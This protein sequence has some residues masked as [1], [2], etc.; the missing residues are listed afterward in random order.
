MG[1]VGLF[2]MSDSKSKRNGK[3]IKTPGQNNQN[4]GGNMSD[5][6]INTLPNEALFTGKTITAADI[7]PWIVP[8]SFEIKPYKIIKKGDPE[9]N[10]QDITLNGA[11]IKFLIAIYL[12]ETALGLNI[13][14]FEI[15][16]FALIRYKTDLEQEFIRPYADVNS[17]NY[18]H[19]IKPIEQQFTGKHIHNGFNLFEIVMY[20]L[21]WSSNYYLSQNNYPYANYEGLSIGLN[22]KYQETRLQHWRMLSAWNIKEDRL[23]IT[24]EGIYG[25]DTRFGVIRNYESKPRADRGLFS[26]WWAEY[27]AKGYNTDITTISGGTLGLKDGETVE[28]YAAII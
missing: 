9:Y 21:P 4:G 6:F 22:I 5:D 17:S 15:E 27:V 25:T 7:V 8:S 2:A 14:T 24:Q 18:V 20:F 10:V 11:R 12:P 1:A 13:E 23:K 19:T 16:D 28:T 3:T 26:E